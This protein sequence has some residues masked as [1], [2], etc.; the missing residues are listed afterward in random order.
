[1]KVW[2]NKEN[3]QLRYFHD[4]EIGKSP[5]LVAASSTFLSLKDVTCVWYNEASH[6]ILHFYFSLVYL[7]M[8][9][10]NL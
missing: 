6:M 10:T 2:E 3:M 9:L 1:M 4:K 8:V 5:T 7:N